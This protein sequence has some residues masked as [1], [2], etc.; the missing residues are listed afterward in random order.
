MAKRGRPARDDIR[1]R[2]LRLLKYADVTGV[3]LA[4]ITADATAGENMGDDARAGWRKRVLRIA[5][6]WVRSPLYFPP[7]IFDT[8]EARAAE[9][10][11]HSRPPDFST[12]PR[13]D[14]DQ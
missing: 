1:V 3:S 14:G 2:I 11:A 9:R 12:L 7:G 10:E 5:F 6:G 4:R 8:P 13:P